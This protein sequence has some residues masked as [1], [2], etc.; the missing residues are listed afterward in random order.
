MPAPYPLEQGFDPAPSGK[1]IP[2]TDDK[3]APFDPEGD[4]SSPVGDTEEHGKD[5]EPEHGGSQ[6]PA[7]DSSEAGQDPEGPPPGRYKSGV[8]GGE[9][10]ACRR[11]TSVRRR[12]PTRPRGSRAGCGG[13]ARSQSWRVGIRGGAAG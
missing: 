3:K 8:V 7:E 1:S 10:E 13:R 2:V 4:D 12:S 6:Q 9:A 11:S 5:A